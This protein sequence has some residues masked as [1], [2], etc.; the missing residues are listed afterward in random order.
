MQ[1]GWEHLLVIRSRRRYRQPSQ[2]RI[3]V[4]YDVLALNVTTM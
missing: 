1:A 4:V 3:Q 2:A